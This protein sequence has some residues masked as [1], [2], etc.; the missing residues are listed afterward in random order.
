MREERR[1][2]P[3]RAQ[4]VSRDH[5]PVGEPLAS[6]DGLV[7]LQDAVSEASQ[8]LYE[9]CAQC[10]RDGPD[11]TDGE[12]GDILIRHHERREDILIDTRIGVGQQ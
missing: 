3:C 7:A 4:R 5:E 6:D 12:R 1:R 9:C 2:A 8:V 11:L 10:D